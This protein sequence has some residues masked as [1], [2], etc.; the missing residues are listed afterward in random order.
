M[1]VRRVS[2]RAPRRERERD[3]DV[4]LFSSRSPSLPRP[5]DNGT[6]LVISLSAF[7]TLRARISRARVKA[8]RRAAGLQKHLDAA[9]FHIARWTMR[10]AATGA[11]R[12]KTTIPSCPA[13]R[14]CLDSV[15]LCSSLFSLSSRLSLSLSLSLSLRCRL[16]SIKPLAKCSIA[17][18]RLPRQPKRDA[19]PVAACALFTRACETAGWLST[20]FS[21]PNANR[22][23]RENVRAYVLEPLRRFIIIEPDISYFLSRLGA[24]ISRKP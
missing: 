12:D 6:R 10:V 18:S 21:Q 14:H 5:A 3:R 19:T 7:A 9:V 2:Q 23:P 20:C 17:R 4:I 24:S 11:M 22:E 1:S 15:S 16:R 8:D 13:D